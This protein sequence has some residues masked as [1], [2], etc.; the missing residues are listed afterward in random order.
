MRAIGYSS[1]ALISFAR[2]SANSISRRGVFSVFL[3][4]TLKITT[5]WLTTVT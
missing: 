3:M 4:K 1:V 2:D 5:R